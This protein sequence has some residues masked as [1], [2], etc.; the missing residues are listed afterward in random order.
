MNGARVESAV[1]WQRRLL[2]LACSAAGALSFAEAAEAEPV[3]VGSTATVGVLSSAPGAQVTLAN[4]RLGATGANVKSPV[5]GTIIH[6]SV[7][8]FQGTWRLRTLTPTGIEYTGGGTS[9]AVSPPS[10]ATHTFS[11]S[12]PVQAGQLIGIENS[13]KT[14]KFGGI[15]AVGS[16][17][18]IFAPPLWE[19]VTEEPDLAAEESEFTFNAEVLPPPQ[20]AS[21]VPATGAVTGGSSVLVAGTNFTEARG[22]SFGAAPAAS[23][24]VV[25]DS[26][27]TATVP[28]SAGITTVPLSVTTA[29][30]TAA[31]SFAYLGCRV[32]A[33]NGGRLKGAKKRIR[34]AGCKVGKVKRKKGVTAKSGRV[35]RQTP[36]AGRV[37]SPGTAV[38]VKL[39]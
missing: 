25:S 34:A 8:G 23:F 10:T 16:I 14:D 6:W 19:G 28:A 17:G 22:V 39:G 30:G 37:L 11:A 26:L 2:A 35:I 33:L 15:P 29:A 18:V 7:T 21:V 27:I 9:A 12:L 31:S 36:K 20:I 32:P 1:G 38:S 3:V 5:S 4:I 24:A 13:S